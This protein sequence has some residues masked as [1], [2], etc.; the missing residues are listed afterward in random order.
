LYEYQ[1]N[2]P[3][4]A[5]TLGGNGTW[6]GT[7]AAALKVPATAFN[8]NASLAKSVTTFTAGASSYVAAEL[9]TTSDQ[10]VVYRA[11]P[12][13]PG[14]Y[15][16]ANNSTLAGTSVTFAWDSSTQGAAA[17][18]TA[19]TLIVGKERGGSEYFQSGS[20]S[21]TTFSQSVNTLPSNGST[22]WVRWSYLVNGA[23]Q[24]TDYSYTAS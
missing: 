8:G 18:A 23:W 16:P 20:L 21:G 4:A 17:G 10:I 3:T 1:F 11:V 9:V 13:A 2:S 24:Y 15:S 12:A 22:V 6:A 14:L 5:D 19:Y 7:T